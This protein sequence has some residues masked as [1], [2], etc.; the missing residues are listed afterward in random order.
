MGFSSSAF[1]LISANAVKVEGF[2]LGCLSV[3]WV[4]VYIASAGQMSQAWLKGLWPSI[5]DLTKFP[6]MPCMK[7]VY[8]DK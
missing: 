1:F 5:E 2:V 4:K 3:F 8:K 6:D 7:R